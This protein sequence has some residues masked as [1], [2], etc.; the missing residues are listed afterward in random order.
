MQKIRH[1]NDQVCARVARSSSSPCVFFL[2]A[3][4]VCVCVLL[5]VRCSHH[6]TAKN[7]RCALYYRFFGV[8]NYIYIYIYF[9]AEA[10]RTLETK[11]KK[12]E[13]KKGGHTHTHFHRRKNRFWW[14]WSLLLFYTAK[15]PASFKKVSAT[16]AKVSGS[17]SCGQ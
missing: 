8:R 15:Q 2:S 5:S 16:V 12:K 17:S 11:L 4:R 14:W 1:K 7:A 10:R 6:W 9:L 13:E 3:L